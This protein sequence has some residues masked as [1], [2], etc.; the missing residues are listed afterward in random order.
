MRY[1]NFWYYK[2]I[3]S[4]YEH[5]KRV[6]K[7]FK[8][9]FIV[10]FESFVQNPET[11]IKEIYRFLGVDDS[12]VPENINEQF[13]PGG[14]Y[15]RNVVTNFIFGRSKL[16]SLVKSVIP[17]N[18]GVKKIVHG[19]TGKFKESTPPM[20]DASEKYLIEYFK[21]DVKRLKEEFGVKVEY[22]NEVFR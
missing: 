9:V 4:Y 1:S 5:I 14:V 2:F 16:N 20:D 11:G 18:S 10:T 3:S 13:N 17:L 7:E 21:D 22:W 19:I 15:K 6:K 12:F 8:D